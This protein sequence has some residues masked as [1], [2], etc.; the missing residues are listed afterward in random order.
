MKRLLLIPVLALGLVGCSSAPEYSF[1]DE[2]SYLRN[3][4]ADGGYFAKISTDED[5]LTLG[6][7][8][9]AEYAKGY[10]MSD[11][12]DSIMDTYDD[13]ETAAFLPSQLAAAGVFL[14]PE[15]ANI[16]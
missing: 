11:L 1:P 14:C 10:T 4:R 12:M 8:A 2:D 5:L 15:D 7:A 13:E 6:Y 16:E 3:V 9:C